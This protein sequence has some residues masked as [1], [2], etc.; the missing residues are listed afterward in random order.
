VLLNPA[1]ADEELTRYTQRTQAGLIQQRANPAFLG[2][3]LYSRIMYGDHPAG[4][5]SITPEGLN[6]RHA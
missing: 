1:F 4:R 6:S 3:E 2:S 5:V